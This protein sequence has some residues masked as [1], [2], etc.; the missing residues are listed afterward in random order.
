VHYFLTFFGEKLGKVLEI[1]LNINAYAVVLFR[2]KGMIIPID[3]IYGIS[4]HRKKA[5]YLVALPI[6]GVEA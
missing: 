3:D 4:P 2:N 1:V 5:G 6:I